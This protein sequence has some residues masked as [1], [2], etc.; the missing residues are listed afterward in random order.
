MPFDDTSDRQ[1]AA[2]IDA[3]RARVERELGRE[4]VAH[5][6]KVRGFSRV[7]EVLGRTL[8]H[9]SLE[10]VT[11]T[12]GVGALWLHKQVEATEIGHTA[13]H[14]A[15]DKLPGADDF[16]S[17]TFSWRLPID[18]ESWRA[19]HNLR[20]H[21]FTNVAGRDPDMELGPIR[22]TARTPHR[23]I[24]YLQVPLT[25]LLWTHFASSMNFHFTGLEDALFRRGPSTDARGALRRALR[26]YA[27]YYGREFVLFPALAGPFWWKV[28]LANWLSEVM[29]DIYSAATIFCGH[30]GSDVVDYPAG[31]HAGGRGE[32]YR[33]QI[34]ATNDYEVPLLV[35]ILCGALDRQ[36]EHH[37]FP[38][39][40]TN[41]LRQVAPE[42]RRACAD[43]GVA[44]RSE[45]WGRTLANAMRR[46]WSLSFP[47][48]DRTGREPRPSEGAARCSSA[49]SPRR[50]SWRWWG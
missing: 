24:H 50:P 35:S 25:L 23:P 3:I 41:R 18:E 47:E 15:F 19:G 39:F 14:G 21:Q 10:P 6:K 7:M 8:I 17:T 22:L 30:I 29:R 48:P 34:E 26:K 43:F 2:R 1:F 4:D 33:M 20:H 27:P 11:L 46:L 16:R 45:S 32:W 5:I 28:L 13:L 31:A 37:L 44:Y 38:R 12:L 40:P 9:V 42:V 49:D 36:I